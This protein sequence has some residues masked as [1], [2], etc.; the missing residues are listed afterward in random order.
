[1]LL[2]ICDANAAPLIQLEMAHPPQL[3][4][5]GFSLFLSRD[6]FCFQKSKENTM[7]Q[8]NCSFVD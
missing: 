4:M 1:M 6:F 2:K 3:Q 7:A 5:N 8:T